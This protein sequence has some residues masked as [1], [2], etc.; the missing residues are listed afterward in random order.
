M[1]DIETVYTVQ[2][3]VTKTQLLSIIAC[4]NRHEF[5][6]G[7]KNPEGVEDEILTFTEVMSK[8][9]LLKYLCEE[10]VEDGVALYDPVEFWTNDGW[11]DVRDFR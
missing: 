10:A 7:R 5:D 8:P 2:V 9:N 1:D 4:L 11:C 6:S 3:N